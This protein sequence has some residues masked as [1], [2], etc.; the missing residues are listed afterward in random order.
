MS[1][2]DQ[3]ALLEL[4]NEIAAA[5]GARDVDRIAALLAPGFVHRAE[6][7]TVSDAAAFVQAIR[8]IPGEILAIGLERVDVDVDG[9]AAMVSGVQ[10]AQVR[11]EGQTIDDR[12][13]FA[14]FFVRAGG[15]WKLRSAA[16]FPGPG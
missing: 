13:A 6:D 16:D 10:F 1:A 5:I 8:D 14:D 9:D 15:V 12:R 4:S 3:S 7:G 11:I 2:S